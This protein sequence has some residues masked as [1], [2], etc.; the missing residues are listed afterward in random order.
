[1]RVIVLHVRGID[2]SNQNVHIQKKPAH[3]NSSRSRCAASGGA[4]RCASSPKFRQAKAR[5]WP[6][7]RSPRPPTFSPSAPFLSQ[8]RARHRRS[9]GW[10]A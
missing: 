6:A 7:L 5:V 1:M 9:R 2:Q 3:R 8:R 4:R 10:C